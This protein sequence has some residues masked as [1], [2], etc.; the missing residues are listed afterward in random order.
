MA[1]QAALLGESRRNRR[2]GGSHAHTAGESTHAHSHAENGYDTLTAEVYVPS[3]NAYAPEPQSSYASPAGDFY[4][5]GSGYGYG[6][7]DGSD[8]DSS[9]LH[10]VVAGLDLATTL[11]IPILAMFGL[12]MLFPNF[13][14][15]N[16]V[17]RKRRG[18]VVM[19]SSSSRGDREVEAGRSRARVHFLQTF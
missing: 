19:T 17:R 3:V 2:D 7:S 15:L 1:P 16:G 8:G 9:P 14:R 10:I 6:A 13:L 4:G 18:A 12:S 11:M 5:A